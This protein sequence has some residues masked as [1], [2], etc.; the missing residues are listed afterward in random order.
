V[1]TGDN[2]CIPIFEPDDRPSFRATALCRGKR[3]LAISA[4]PA[5]GMLGTENMRCAEAGA[6]AQAVGVNNY[7]VQNQEEGGMICSGVVPMPAGAAIVA[8]NK[9]MSDAQGRPVPW[10]F[11]ASDANNPLGLALEDQAVV[12]N[13][14]AI[15]LFL[16]S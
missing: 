3:F 12:G 7:E 16:P 1:A 15:K 14:C 8:G 2:V 6:G 9:V 13:D 11:A 5:G 10:V 4:S